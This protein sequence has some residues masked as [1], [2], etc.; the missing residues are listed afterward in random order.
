MAI[1]IDPRQ[2]LGKWLKDHPRANVAHRVLRYDRQTLVC[3]CGRAIPAGEAVPP[4]GAVLCC[5]DCTGVWRRQI[6]EKRKRR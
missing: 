5:P 4:A 1:A 6:A 3:Y 2:S